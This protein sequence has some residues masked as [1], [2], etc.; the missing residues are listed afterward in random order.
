[1]EV[2]LLKEVKVIIVAIHQPNYIPWVGYFYKIYKSDIFIILD[3]VQYVKNGFADRNKIKTPQGDCY[4][5]IPVEA[6]NT[7]SKYCN[8]RLKDELNWREKHLKTIEMNYKKSKYFKEIFNDLCNIYNNK[9]IT[10]LSEFNSLIIE[11]VVK[12]LGINTKIIYSKD[13]N[14]EL[15]RTDRLV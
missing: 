12:K 9:D 5:K 2:K 10:I 15:E 13:L 1:M 8:V 11:Y 6:K 7:V 3:D 4:L 14:V